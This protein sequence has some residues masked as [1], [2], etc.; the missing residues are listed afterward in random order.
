[1]PDATPAP[2]VGVQ[3]CLGT[4]EARWAI[5]ASVLGS[6]TV[7][8]ESTVVSV[9]L[10]DLGR[11][12]GLGIA[13][14]Q[15]VVSGYLVTLSA[16]LLLGGALGDALGQRVVFQAGLLSFAG[17][18]A[19]TASAPTLPLLV[20]ARLLQG[21]AGAL[22]VPSSLALLD[23][24]FRQEDR[25]AAIGLWASW[26]RGVHPTSFEALDG[27]TAA[28]DPTVVDD[29]EDV[30]LLEHHLPD[31]LIEGLDGGFRNDV[32]E[33]PGMMDIPC[34]LVGTGAVAPVFV[35]NADRP[36]WSWRCRGVATFA[37]LERSWSATGA[38]SSRRH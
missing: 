31:E 35:L 2:A 27:G 29:P 37:Q 38:G 6:G 10:P 21:A 1:M 36:P 11:D 33:E 7:F 24:S 13:G 17:S 5:A 12:L 16:L 26:S 8:V 23:T 34:S 14:I 18:S 28:V 9:A 3:L 32:T 15:W 30:G 22:L 25:S 4:R 19:L 20:T